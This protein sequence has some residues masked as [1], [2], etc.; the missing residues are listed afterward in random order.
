MTRRIPRHYDRD[1][2]AAGN[3]VEAVRREIP[4]LTDEQAEQVV[5]LRAMADGGFH[6][7]GRTVS[8]TC[9]DC[10]CYGEWRYSGNAADFIAS[11]HRGHQT[12]VGISNPPV[13][14]PESD[15]TTNLPSADTGFTSI[16]RGE[17][18]A[19]PAPHFFSERVGKFSGGAPHKN[20]A[21]SAPRRRGPSRERSDE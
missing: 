9:I 19:P 21:V 15:D 7:T 8:V 5:F 11:G 16:G 17:N 1:R 18:S 12:V 14:S 4:G 13:T 20:S 2:D 10:Q 6:F 3:V